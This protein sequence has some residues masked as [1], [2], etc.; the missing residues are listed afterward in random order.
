MKFYVDVSMKCYKK[1]Y[2]ELVWFVNPFV[3]N[4]NWHKTDVILKL[5]MR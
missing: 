1:F 5:M 3:W 4:Y 2:A